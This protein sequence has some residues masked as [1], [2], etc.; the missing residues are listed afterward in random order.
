[1]LTVELPKEVPKRLIVSDTCIS[2]TPEGVPVIPLHIIWPN[3]QDQLDSEFSE[4]PE[5]FYVK[6]QNFLDKGL[7]LPTT[8]QP[9]VAEFSELYT[10]LY[11]RGAR[12]VGSVHIIASKSGTYNNA[13]LAA[14]EVMAEHPDMSIR[15]MDSGA[16]SLLQM[17]Q[18]EIA[19]AEQ[20]KGTSLENINRILTQNAE[21]N[22][23][24]H[25]ALR[26]LDNAAAGGRVS[27]AKAKL[28]ELAHLKPIVWLKEADLVIQQGAIGM[29]PALQRIVNN[30]SDEIDKRKTLPSHVGTMYTRDRKTGDLLQELLY[31]TLY[32]TLKK[33]EGIIFEGPTEATPLLGIHAGPGAGALAALW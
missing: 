1:M 10:E 33:K 31:K 27:D 16:L 7:G 32:E 29:K 26:T 19:V 17:F 6:M 4:N 12:E 13:V 3:K 28:A 9:S 2:K 30:L 20:Q 5:D 23:L 25:V 11:R 24:F 15:A 22:I 8:A 14:R 18:V 21:N